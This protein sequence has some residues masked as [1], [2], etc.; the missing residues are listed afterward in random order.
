M[1]KRRILK[2]GATY[3]VTARANRG[4]LILKSEKIKKLFDS[5]L[6]RAK[7]KYKFVIKNYC[8][9]NNHIH[10][11]ILPLKNENLSRI[12]QWILATFAIN[13]NK[14]FQF[15][16]HVWYD[17]FHS[18]IINSFM[19]FIRTFLYISENPVKANI[20]KYSN[21]YE[22]GGIYHFYKGLYEIIEPPEIAL[23][24]VF[25]KIS[26]KAIPYFKKN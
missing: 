21:Q 14:I 9:M 3:H 8:I 20:V 17:R 19:Q 15:S 11:M 26:L 18:K 13:Y 25:P 24:L 4:E 1:R 6:K 23:K 10:L 12:M 16:G 5:I 22:H 7:K 2:N